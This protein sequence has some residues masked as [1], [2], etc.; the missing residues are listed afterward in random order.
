MQMANFNEIRKRTAWQI[1]LLILMYAIFVIAV[2]VYASFIGGTQQ[3]VIVTVRPNVPGSP[4]DPSDLEG[5]PLANELSHVIPV[6][7][8]V[9]GVILAIT[10]ASVPVLAVTTLI[11]T[12]L[13]TVT[14][15]QL[16]GALW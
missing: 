3:E 8:A 4:S 13:G 1:S 10:F 11:I 5:K 15:S 9:S 16:L 2:P 14:L 6:A 12:A 7:F